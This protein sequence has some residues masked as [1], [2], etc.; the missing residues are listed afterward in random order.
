M[1]SDA[2]RLGKEIASL[3][4]SNGSLPPGGWLAVTC[5]LTACTPRSAPGPTLGNES[6]KTLRL[7]FFTYLLTCRVAVRS[8]GLRVPRTETSAARVVPRTAHRSVPAAGVVARRRRRVDHQL[9][10]PPVHRHAPQHHHPSHS[11]TIR[12]VSTF[13]LSPRCRSGARRRRGIGRGETT[14]PSSAVRWCGRL[15]NASEAAPATASVP[16]RL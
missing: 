8:I 15:A 14:C 3:A 10:S 7:T 13:D 1:G 9:S 5:G 11:Q 2:L 16:F 4:E 12:V 6:G